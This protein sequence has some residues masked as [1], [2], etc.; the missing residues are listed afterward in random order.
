MKSYKGSL[1]TTFFE[2]STL[3]RYRLLKLMNHVFLPFAWKWRF[4]NFSW[5]YLLRVELSFRKK[6]SSETLYNFSRSIYSKRF[7]LI[8]FIFIEIW[9]L[10]NVDFT[11]KSRFSVKVFARYCNYKKLLQ[12]SFYE[13][14]K[15]WCKKFK[16][17]CV[18]QRRACSKF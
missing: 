15:D 3:K 6:S 10:E 18:L 5:R 11:L 16:Q 4:V 17:V 8:G 2:N 1:K 9:H 13:N 14:L 7:I 12:C